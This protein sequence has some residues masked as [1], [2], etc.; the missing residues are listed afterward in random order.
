MVG[1]GRG[2]GGEPLARSL[3][4]R[5]IPPEPVDRSSRVDPPYV[6]DARLG[7]DLAPV[8]PGSRVGWTREGGADPAS[9]AADL[10]GFSPIAARSKPVVV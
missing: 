10:P 6:G 8:R 2:G 4:G 1:V 7:S 5:E 3:T 9:A